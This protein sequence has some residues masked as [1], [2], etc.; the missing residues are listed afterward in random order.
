MIKSHERVQESKRMFEE[1]LE[2]MNE[3]LKNEGL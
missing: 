3:K 2:R 1:E